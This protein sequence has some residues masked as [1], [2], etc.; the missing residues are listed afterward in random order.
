MEELD[1]TADCTK[2]TLSPRPESPEYP[3]LKL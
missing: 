1:L 3:Q 2:C